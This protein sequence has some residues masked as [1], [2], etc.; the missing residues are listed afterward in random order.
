MMAHVWARV[1]TMEQLL[2]TGDKVGALVLSPIKFAGFSNDISETSYIAICN[3]WRSEL[4]PFVAQVNQNN[5]ILSVDIRSTGL[6][7]VRVSLAVATSDIAAIKS[8]LQNLSGIP[9]S[10]LRTDTFL[11]D[12]A[13]FSQEI[14]VDVGY[15]K[16]TLRYNETCNG[17]MLSE[18]A[19]KDITMLLVFGCVVTLMFVAFLVTIFVWRSKQY[20]DAMKEV[21]TLKKS[22]GRK[23]KKKVTSKDSQIISNPRESSIIEESNVPNPA[24]NK[25]DPN[26]KSLEIINGLGS[27]ASKRPPSSSKKKKKKQKKGTLAEVPVLKFY[28]AGSLLCLIYEFLGLAM[29][30][31]DGTAG[32]GFQVIITIALLVWAFLKRTMTGTVVLVFRLCIGFSTLTATL[33]TGYAG[34]FFSTIITGG[35]EPVPQMCWYLVGG[36]PIAWPIMLVAAIYL[37][38]SCGTGM[39]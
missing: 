37:I 1:P 6:D 33:V 23:K 28:L 15:C 10:A 18:T 11:G 3:R 9:D 34:T 24:L 4:E 36:S 19:Q 21:E 22:G 27:Q 2:Q 16:S 26:C 17:G 12:T 5:T 25:E 7:R 8:H 39:T 13:F 38:T 14:V 30:L 32:V 29:Y 31:V 20:S 35:A